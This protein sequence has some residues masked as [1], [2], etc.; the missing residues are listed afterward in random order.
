VGDVLDGTE[1]V[2][3]LN[4]VITPEHCVTN[5]QLKLLEMFFFRSQPC[6]HEHSALPA[7]LTGAF[8]IPAFAAEPTQEE[9]KYCAHDYRQYCNEDG[10]GSE[11]LT[12]C[13]RKHGTRKHGKKLSAQCIKA[14]EDA[15][16]LTPAEEAEAKKHGM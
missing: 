1:I 6:L 10:I 16:E 12:L 7:E 15:G 13:M 14:L 11:L 2:G 5:D 8:C 9:T 4:S 3:A